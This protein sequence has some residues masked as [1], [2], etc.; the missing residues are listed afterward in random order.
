MSDERKREAEEPSAARQAAD[1]PEPDWA[2]QIR[3]L[4]KQRGDRLK[5]LLGTTDDPEGAE[6][7]P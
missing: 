3:A 5:H 2:E 6:F 7:E 4:R 1:E